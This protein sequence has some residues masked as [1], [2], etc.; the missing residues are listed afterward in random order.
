MALLLREPIVPIAAFADRLFLHPVRTVVLAFS[1]M[2]LAG[3]ALLSQP[4]ASQSGQPTPFIDALFTAVSALCVTGL[5]T[6]DTGTHWS[7]FGLALILL[8]IQLGG[9]GLMLVAT[10]LGSLIWSRLSIAQQRRTSAEM[11]ALTLSG[12]LRA[13]VRLIILVAL[14]AEALL[15]ILLA[16]RFWWGHDLPA[17]TAI[18]H[19]VF[20]S[21]SAYNNAGFGLRA[22]SLMAFASDPLVLVP[23]AV[24]II[25]GG[26]GFPVL[27]DIRHQRWERRRWSMH[28][29]VTV[30]GTALLLATGFVATTVFE[31]NGALG[32]LSIGD[33][34]LNAA[35]YSVS[36]R[37]AGFNS[38]AMDSLSNSTLVISSALMF[39]GA[40]VASTGGGIKVATIMVLLL[41]VRSELRG[42]RDVAAF[43]RRISSAAQRRAIAII[44]VGLML[45]V[46]AALALSVLSDLP[47]RDV[48]FEAVSAFGTVGLSTGI[49]AQL[50][51]S[52]K[53]IIIFLMFAGRVGPVTLGAALIIRYRQQSFRY[54]QEDPIIG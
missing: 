23:I 7:G 14:V 10:L 2:S 22:D 5:A 3:G 37:T 46:S 27:W 4:I 36:L 45:V 38:F 41:V 42:D 17:V 48:A 33:R 43:G 30:A 1:S 52:G 32:D 29:R 13:A 28:S 26:I 50:P 20:H 9:L 11:S 6:V 24:A 54:P 21:I 31:W 47:M 35:F 8:L 51:D 39:V 44:L 19:G 40:G 49:T 18:W 34:V 53:A 25:V 16:L 15:A 12:D